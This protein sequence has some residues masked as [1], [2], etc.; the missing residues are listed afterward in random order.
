MSGHDIT[1]GRN[2][3]VSDLGLLAKRSLYGSW[4]L[5]TTNLITARPAPDTEF[6]VYNYQGR[7][8]YQGKTNQD[9]MVSIFDMALNPGVAVSGKVNARF[10]ARVFEPSGVF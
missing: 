1:K 9:G 7:M 4:S 6:S 2:A 8:L 10:M 5:T 3:Y